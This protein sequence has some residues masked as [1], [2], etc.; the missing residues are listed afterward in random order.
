MIRSISYR[1]FEGTIV[2]LTV[3]RPDDCGDVEV[4]I[5]K[6][7][8]KDIRAA[9]AVD[10][11]NTRKLLEL[12]RKDSEAPYKRSRIGFGAIAKLKC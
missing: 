10:P 11:A 1:L 6:A 8:A 2:K 12:V 3:D 7:T 5:D 9:R 4:T